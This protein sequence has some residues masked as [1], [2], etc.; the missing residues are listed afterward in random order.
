MME[1]KNGARPYINEK[2]PDI[3]KKLMQRCWSQDKKER[4]T[5][6]EI[7]KELRT[8]KEFILPTVDEQEFLKYV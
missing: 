5:F 1:V 6:A 4:P 2:V 3:Y 8:N 7:V